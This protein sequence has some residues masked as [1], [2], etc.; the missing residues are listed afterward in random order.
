[1]T[2]Q[3]IWLRGALDAPALREIEAI[4]GDKLR[5]GE[6]LKL[7]RPLRD[8]LAPVTQAVQ[9]QFPKMEPVRALAFDKTPQ[10]N[11]VLPWHQDRVIAV[12]H[13]HDINGYTS[14]T[15]KSGI[16][17]CEP[18]VNILQRMLFVRVHID[19]ADATTG[20]MEIAEGSHTDGIIPSEQA[21]NIAQSHPRNVTVAQRGDILILP[22]LTLHRSIPAQ[23]PSRR[24]TLRIDYAD[25][26]LDGPLSWAN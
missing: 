25:F 26:A 12:S 22:M 23:A 13:R 4:F 9:E 17:H 19:D 18:P 3:L 24:R 10:S 5:A 11:W 8:R 21:E 15:R 1:M 2:H 7:D 6:R 20:A 16:W 14:W